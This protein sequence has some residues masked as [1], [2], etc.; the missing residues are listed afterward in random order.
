MSL[1]NFESHRAAF[2]EAMRIANAS[3]ATIRSRSDLLG[4]FIRFLEQSG[5]TDAREVTRETVQA[6]QLALIAAGLTVS[7]RIAHLQTA[8]RF[9]AHLE[10]TDV[11][12]VNPCDGVRSPKVERAL[13]RSLTREQARQLID[14]PDTNTPKGIRDRAILELFYS[15]GIRLAEMVALELHDVDC[16][17]GL[18]R[19][20]QGKGRKDRI[21]PMGSKAGEAVQRYLRE[22]RSSWQRSG[23]AGSALWLSAIEP[24][25]PLT[26]LTVQV[27]VRTYGRQIGVAVTPHLWRHTCATHLVSNGANIA[28]VQRLLGHASLDSTQIYTR[29]AVPEL[30]ATHA[31]KHP[32]A[33]AKLPKS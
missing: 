22:A 6:H 31:R 3:P 26:K 9:F 29:V 32:R 19:V 14:A 10:K 2:I 12:L 11:I 7:T 1:A 21:V 27:M 8:R 5:I 20:T 23:H 33:K 18:L 17:S 13:P 30:Q 15:T 24:H 16:R 25:A 28:Y 4:Q